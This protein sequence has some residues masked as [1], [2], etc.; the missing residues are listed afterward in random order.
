MAMFFK[1]AELQP[2]EVKPLDAFP[3]ALPAG[4]VSGIVFADQLAEEVFVHHLIA[5]ALKDGP[6]Y[7]IGPGAL[8]VRV[9]EELSESVSNL[10]A[11]NAYTVEEL[12]EALRLVE[13]ASLVIVRRFPLLLNVSAENVVELKRTADEKGLFLVLCHPSLEL[14]ELDLPGEFGKLFLLPELFDLLAVLRTSSYRGHHRMNI[15]VLRAPAEYV[16]SVGD[17]SVPIDSLARPFLHRG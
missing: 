10:Y 15:T 3:V 16:A 13:D 17:H 7:H 14:N 6:V 2:R 11:G 9:L 8:S 12:M 4:S 5:S 1:P